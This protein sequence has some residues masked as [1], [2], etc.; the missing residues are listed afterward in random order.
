MSTKICAS[1]EEKIIS[2][3]L[4][5]LDCNKVQDTLRKLAEPNSAPLEPIK[6]EH[7]DLFYQEPEVKTEVSFYV[8]Y[9]L[10]IYLL[11]LS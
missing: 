9:R 6:T 1:C 2:F 3:H 4:F 10:A 8:V 5:I 11:A 7:Y